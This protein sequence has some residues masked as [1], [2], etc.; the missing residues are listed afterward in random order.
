MITP[1]IHEGIIQT[2]IATNPGTDYQWNLPFPTDIFSSRLP[3]SFLLGNQNYPRDRK[4]VCARLFIRRTSTIL[5]TLHSTNSDL[6]ESLHLFSGN[7]I[8]CLALL[9]IL[10]TNMK[11]AV[12]VLLASLSLFTLCSSLDDDYQEPVG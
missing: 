7:W 9:K 5:H 12:I 8:L 10:T 1:R 2:A 4:H 11:L 6:I 3:L